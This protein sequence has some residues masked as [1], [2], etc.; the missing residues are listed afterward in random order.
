[1]KRRSRSNMCMEPP[2]PLRDARLAP[3][4]LGH[5]PLGVGPAHERV[6]VGAVG[7]DEEVVV[8]RGARGADD[9]PLLADSQVQEPPIFALAYIS[10]ARSSKRRMSCMAASHSRATSGSGSSCW[11]ALRAV[12]AMLGRAYPGPADAHLPCSIQRRARA[13][14]GAAVPPRP[15]ARV[16]AAPPRCVGARPPRGA[17]RD[18][19]RRL[20]ARRDPRPDDRGREGR[21]LVD[22][23]RRAGRARAPGSSRA[24]RRA[25]T[26]SSRWRRP[27]RSKPCC[28]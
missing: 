1:M 21:P 18:A 3:E 10:P 20:P 11:S 19:R 4:E 12:P 25:A 24:A 6:A 5:D 26:W 17:R 2:R 7:R 16:G 14:V 8:P 23:A 15:L 28:A 27:R 9:R 13:G 22:V